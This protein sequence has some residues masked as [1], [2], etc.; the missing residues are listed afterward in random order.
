MV[1]PDHSFDDTAAHG[2]RLLTGDHGVCAI[3]A[4]GDVV[5]GRK[6]CVA[7]FGEADHAVGGA[8]WWVWSK[9]GGGVFKGVVKSR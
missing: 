7:L 6:Q 1:H 4:Q 2:T 8:S 9:G 5:A 3:Q